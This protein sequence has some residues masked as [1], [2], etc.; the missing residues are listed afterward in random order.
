MALKGPAL[1]AFL[2]R[3]SGADRVEV[4]ACDKLSGGAIQENWLL[5]ARF[6]SGP[7]TGRQDLVLRR[8]SP[9]GVAV[10]RSRHEEFRLLQVARDAGV[11][12]PEPLW[13]SDGDEVL[14]RPFYVM[15]HCPGTAAGHLLV[16]EGTVADGEALVEDLGRELA[17]LHAIRPPRDD[18]AF[19]GAPP[20]DPAQAAVARYRSHLDALERPFP[21]LEWGLRWCDLHAPPPGET[22]LLHQDYRTGNYLVADGRLTGVLDWEFA[23]WGDAMSDLGWFCAKCWRFG[24]NER[25]AGGIGSR[26]A[27]Y[28]GYE[29]V[30][31]RAVEG[32]RVAYWEVMAHL[33]WAVIALQQGERF[34]KG[35]EASLDLALT[36]RVRPD[37]LAFEILALTPPQRWSRG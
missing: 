13:A 25:E 10:S 35:G 24:R 36:G 20:A 12:V 3:A 37:E 8:D 34:T 7:L 9:T 1:E 14:G 19:L 30:A 5:H 17:R 15:R 27:F 28:R 16:K 29:S 33:R 21:A 31:G 23:A 22:V 2:A 6:G 18:L 32:E 26:S 4:L 11:T